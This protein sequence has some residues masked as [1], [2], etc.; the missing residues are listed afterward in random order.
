MLNRSKRKT[1]HPEVT[2]SYEALQ[3]IKLSSN[4]GLIIEKKLV[5]LAEIDLDPSKY[6]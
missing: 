5:P 3:P 2:G 4:D 6:S 1:A